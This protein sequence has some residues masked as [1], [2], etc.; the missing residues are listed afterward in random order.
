MQAVV[1]AVAAFIGQW[2]L[3]G[4]GIVAVSGG[5]DS[6]ALL[7]AM[8]ELG[9]FDLHVA[10]VNHQLRGEESDTDEGLVK[11]L[12]ARLQLPFHTV[13]RPLS[14]DTAIE[15]SAR[16]ARY[17]WLQELARELGC[18]WIATGH[19]RDDQVETLLHHLIRGTGLDGLHGI[20]ARRDL[21]NDGNLIRPLLG[22]THAQNLD[23][24]SRIPQPHR[25]DASNRD[26]RF[27]RNRIRHELVPLLKTFNPE[28]GAA[29][30]RFQQLACEAHAVV[31]QDAQRML[32]N[33]ERPRVG[34]TIILDSRS[35]DD[36]PRPVVRE[37]FRALWRRERWPA[38]DMTA[39][40]WDDLAAVA[41]G[42]VRA[43][44]MPGGVRVEYAGAV[45]RLDSSLV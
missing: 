40:R 45:I 38:G 25:E 22:V 19:T 21:G 20:D 3:G 8:H 26:P 27:T 35:L 36:A 10:H 31:S 41:A 16:A 42:K 28:V 11:E 30:L 44:D 4:R 29:L 33:A 7:W 23:Y 12:A 15:A 17:Q 34:H 18:H 43:V 14:A 9:G 13:K 2:P 5:A 1:D 32:A 39:A 6:V 24:L 37:M